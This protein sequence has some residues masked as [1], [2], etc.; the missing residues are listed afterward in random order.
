MTELGRFR[1]ARLR[2]AFLSLLALATI[3]AGLLVVSGSR[4]QDTGF[5]G[6]LQHLFGF[7][8]KP[9]P[10][11]RA[12][13]ASR[14]RTTRAKDYV[15]PSTTRAASASANAVAPTDF[16]SVL[17]DSL[18]IKAAQGLSEAFA[19]RP[20]ISISTLARDLSGLT[21][22]DVYDWSKAARELLAGGKQKID[23][24]VVMVGI[25]DV[26]PLK[27]GGSTLDTLSDKW[28][29]VYGQRVED[30]IAPFRDA[31]VPVLWLGLPPMPDERFNAQVLALNEL[32]REHVEKAGGV[33]IDIWDG[34]ADQNGQYAAFGPDV[35]GENARLRSA[36]NGI[37]FTKS[38]Q[39][40]LAQYLEADIRRTIDKGKTSTEIT[41][42]PPDIEQ[43][44]YDVNAE[45][46]REMGLDRNMASTPLLPPRMEAGPILSLT[47]RPTAANAI[48]VGLS[49]LAPAS[50]SVRLG[51]AAE[52]QRGR[53]DDFAWPAP[54]PTPAAGGSP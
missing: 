23:V 54:Q 32:Y 37:Y 30:M 4:A 7:T 34:F 38:G 3:C 50:Q 8:A 22:T 53:A 26:Q 48:L 2:S 52:P 19:S 12:T 9:P 31:H 41:A 33:Y 17:G 42:L 46:R 14:P 24:A 28:K 35:D 27:D 39:R 6:F 11:P 1:R 51:R 29:A 49:G 45:I 47:A 40:K 36:A 43:E 44:A 21:R 25:N 20:E 15:S 18:A 5:P 16:V 13:P 10:P